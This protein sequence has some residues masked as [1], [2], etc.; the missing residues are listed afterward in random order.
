[1]SVLFKSCN[2]CGLDVNRWRACA[3][4]PAETA[5]CDG[6]GGDLL[7]VERMTEHVTLRHGTQS[8]PA[9]T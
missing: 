9:S 8:K 6:C 1:M 5:F 7:A 2:G 3:F 4:C